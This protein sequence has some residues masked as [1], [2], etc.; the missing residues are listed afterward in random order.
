M[1]LTLTVVAGVGRD[2][3][4]GGAGLLGATDTSIFG[5]VAAWVGLVALIITTAASW[6]KSRREIRDREREFYSD[7]AAWSGHRLDYVVRRSKGWRAP[8]AESHAGKTWVD[9]LARARLL[10]KSDRVLLAL[11]RF[12]WRVGDFE[13]WIDEG[14]GP[15]LRRPPAIAIVDLSKIERSEKLDAVLL[16]HRELIDAIRNELRLYP[17]LWGIYTRN[18]PKL[19]WTERVDRFVRRPFKRSR[20]GPVE[21]GRCGRCRVSLVQTK[22][23]KVKVEDARVAVID[24]VPATWCPSC[25]EVRFVVNLTAL[26]EVADEMLATMPSGHTKVV[27][28]FREPTPAP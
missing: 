23:P 19:E 27:R 7:L 28:P 8:T 15:P 6:L 20:T 3:P 1:E 2:G 11:T 22:R 18:D 10:K 24:D 17:V 4:S 9:Y 13:K 14:N 25:D 12:N 16:A 21:A 26:E 5:Q